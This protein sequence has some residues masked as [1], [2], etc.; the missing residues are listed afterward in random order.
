MKKTNISTEINTKFELLPWLL[1][2]VRNQTRILLIFGSIRARSYVQPAVSRLVLVMVFAAGLGMLFSQQRASERTRERMND[3]TNWINTL[4]CL[5]IDFMSTSMLYHRE[6]HVDAQTY[7]KSIMIIRILCQIIWAIRQ[8]N[9][10]NGM[11][12]IELIYWFAMK[13]SNA[14]L[15]GTA[16]IRQRKS[17]RA[18]ERGRANETRSCELFHEIW[19]IHLDSDFRYRSRNCCRIY[20]IYQC[21]CAI[22]HFASLWQQVNNG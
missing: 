12:E 6:R 4:A 2:I 20:S 13:S 16:P 3:I 17:E 19:T 15:T 11:N 10:S 1:I 22:K 5:C 7:F 21:H 9:V 18:S 14:Q 8:M